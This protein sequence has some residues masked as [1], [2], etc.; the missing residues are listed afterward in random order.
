LWSA[1][2]Y[3]GASIGS[4]VGRAGA[5]G[6]A[7]LIILEIA[8]VALTV[9]QD[10][11]ASLDDLVEIALDYGHINYVDAT[12]T[13]VQESHARSARLYLDNAYDWVGLR[14]VAGQTLAWPRRG[15][16]DLD[17]LPIPDDHVPDAI[18]V[19]EALLMVAA[20]AGPL[21]GSSGGSGNPD[22]EIRRESSDDANLDR[23]SLFA[24]R[25]RPQ[26]IV[27]SQTAYS[28]CEELAEERFQS[29]VYEVRLRHR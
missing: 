3:A 21:A 13:L 10:T 2:C 16:V 20:G 4:T 11:Y 9:G 7:G 19:A 29:T 15:V 5:R 14:A 24:R 27:A 25:L 18:I 6:P 1:P 22:R 12:D 23:R 17:G 26:Q 8:L 28:F